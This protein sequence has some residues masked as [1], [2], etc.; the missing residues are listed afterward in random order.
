LDVTM[1][2]ALQLYNQKLK[3]NAENYATLIDRGKVELERLRSLK[4][5][6][7]MTKKDQMMEKEQLAVEASYQ[8]KKAARVA[9]E[10]EDREVRLKR[11]RDLEIA[12]AAAAPGGDGASVLPAVI[13]GVFAASAAVALSTGGRQG[14]DNDGAM[15]TNGTDATP[16]SPT[17]DLFGNT[18]DQENRIPSWDLKNPSNPTTSTKSD[19]ALYGETNSIDRITIPTPMNGASSLYKKPSKTEDERKQDA[20][21]AMQEYLDQDDGGDAWLQAMADIIDEDEGDAEVDK[22]IYVNGSDEPTSFDKINGSS[23]NL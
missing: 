18:T 10:E 6:D 23:E 16:S 17:T 4:D 20:R 12:R 8:K 5:Q 2:S 15:M 22:A 9:R 19:G 1:D 11:Q 13:G 3:D 21:E 14:K 7:I